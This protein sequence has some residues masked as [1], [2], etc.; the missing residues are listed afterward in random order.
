MSDKLAISAHILKIVEKTQMRAE[1]MFNLHQF[2][3]TNKEH[4]KIKLTQNETNLWSI[5]FL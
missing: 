1:K 5:F 4:V 2:F 3:S